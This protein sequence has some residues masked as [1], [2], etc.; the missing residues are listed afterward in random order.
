MLTLLTLITPI[1]S[2]FIIKKANNV[3]NNVII[4]NITGY[5]MC[6]CIC[7]RKKYKMH[8]VTLLVAFLGKYGY[9]EKICEGVSKI[10]YY[11]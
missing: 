6:V 9:S 11:R 2:N 1:T 8:Y 5:P 4:N 7:R 3:T 10:T